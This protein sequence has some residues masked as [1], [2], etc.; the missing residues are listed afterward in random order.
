[1]LFPSLFLTVNA[2]SVIV[3]VPATSKLLDSVVA[4]ETARASDKV[5]APVTLKVS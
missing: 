2:P 3:V 5:V 4:P 1:M